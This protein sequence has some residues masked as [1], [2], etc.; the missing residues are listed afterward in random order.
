MLRRI[1]RQT[2][3]RVSLSGRCEIW[4]SPTRWGPTPS[5]LIPLS[6]NW[7]NKNQ[8]LCSVGAVSRRP[9]WSLN[10]CETGAGNHFSQSMMWVCY[11]ACFLAR[12]MHLFVYWKGVELHL[13]RL[14]LRWWK[15]E[16]WMSIRTLWNLATKSVYLA[17]QNSWTLYCAQDA[18][19]T[20]GRLLGRWV[21]GE[22][23]RLC[24]WQLARSVERLAVSPWRPPA[25]T[26]DH[27]GSMKHQQQLFLLVAIFCSQIFWNIFKYKLKF[28]ITNDHHRSFKYCVPHYLARLFPLPNIL[29]NGLQIPTSNLAGGVIHTFIFP[30]Y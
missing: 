25:V 23:A 4:T 29:R 19:A 27:Q 24:G 11:Y 20:V 14:D 21:G 6:V 30:Q 15:Y 8:S 16:I 1:W 17:S 10:M 22:V 12:W 9:G 18:Q 5:R 26:S 7:Q 2:L 13:L 3:R 28:Q